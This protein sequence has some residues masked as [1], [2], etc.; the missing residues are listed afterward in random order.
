MEMEVSTGSLQFHPQKMARFQPA[1]EWNQPVTL[2]GSSEGKGGSSKATDEPG[3]A[4]RVAV[5]ENQ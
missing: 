1:I 5:V 4:K 2:P 3:A